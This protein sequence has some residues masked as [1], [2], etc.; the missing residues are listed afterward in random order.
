MYKTF[1]FDASSIFRNILVYFAEDLIFKNLCLHLMDFIIFTDV[2]FQSHLTFKYGIKC[3]GVLTQRQELINQMISMNSI[4]LEGWK[5]HVESV[6]DRKT[7]YELLLH[8]YENAR[9]AL[10]QPFSKFL[11]TLLF[12]SLQFIRLKI[13][14]IQVY[15]LYLSSE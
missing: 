4:I 2:F 12:R 1:E 15:K 6:A 11:Y 5:I 13:C 3:V 8:Q 10:I 14:W 7:R 9:L